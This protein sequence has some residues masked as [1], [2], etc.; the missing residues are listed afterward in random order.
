[1]ARARIPLASGAA[2]QLVVD[3]HRVV[4][5]GPDDVQP[6]RGQDFLALPGAFLPQSF[7]FRRREPLLSGHHLRVPAQD[8]VRAAAGHVR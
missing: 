7:E 6:T 8:D 3:A 2:A 5:G 4:M 1:M